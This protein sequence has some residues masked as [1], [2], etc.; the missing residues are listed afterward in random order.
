MYIDLND[1]LNGYCSINSLGELNKNYSVTIFIK[2]IFF[3][4]TSIY[5]T[6]ISDC[7]SITILFELDKL[8]ISV[9]GI[10]RSPQCILIALF[11]I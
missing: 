6:V 4:V 1:I 5:K 2:N 3:T 8:K 7:N 10:Y 9:I 11:A